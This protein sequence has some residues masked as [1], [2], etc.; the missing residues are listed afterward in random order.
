MVLVAT[1][2]LAPEDVVMVCGKPKHIACVAFTAIQALRRNA[3]MPSE[4]E[5]RQSHKP[6]PETL[7]DTAPDCDLEVRA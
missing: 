6:H 4:S 1:V 2:T 7:G 3:L 5:I